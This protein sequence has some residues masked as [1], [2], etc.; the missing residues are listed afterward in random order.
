MG[1]K[2]DASYTRKYDSPPKFHREPWRSGSRGIDV[3]RS[4]SRRARRGTH[5]RG[6]QIAGGC[7]KP[8]VHSFHETLP[9]GRRNPSAGPFTLVPP[10]RGE[11]ACEH[12]DRR[13]GRTARRNAA[14][15]DAVG[16]FRTALH[17]EPESLSTKRQ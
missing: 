1:A 12:P 3:S 5:G 7:E 8:V 17:E 4:A 15:S 11:P 10:R 13:Q 16:F 14:A 9:D 6:G 2:F